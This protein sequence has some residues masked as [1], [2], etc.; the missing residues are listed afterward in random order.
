MLVI[1]GFFAIKVGPN[2]IIDHLKARLVP[3]GY[4]QI[5]ELLW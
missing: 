1:G 2:G 4:T 5:F 3:K